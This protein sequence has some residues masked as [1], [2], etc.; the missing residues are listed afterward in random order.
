M[1]STNALLMDQQTILLIGVIAV[2]FLYIGYRLG[3][4][5]ARFSERARLPEIRRM[6]AAR[7]RSVLTGQFS[8]QLAPFLPDFPYSPTEAR[9]LGR[10]VDFVVFRGLDGRDPTEIVFVEVKSGNA[11]LSTAERRLREAVESGRVRWE[12]YRVPH[13]LTER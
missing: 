2:V 4:I 8:E 12:E 11:S 13:G 3:R 10:P 9:F 7:S 1:D 6:A 5:I